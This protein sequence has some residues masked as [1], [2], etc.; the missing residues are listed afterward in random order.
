MWRRRRIIDEFDEIEREID[1]LFEEFFYGKPMWSESECLEPLAY[2]NETDD[3]IVVTV[4]LPF[5]KK[6]DIKLDVTPNLLKIE[7]KMQK[8]VIYDRWGTVQRRC[9][10]KTFHKEVK[11]PSEVIP[12]LTKAKFKNGYLIVTLP[13]KVRRHKIEIE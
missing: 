10:F 3:L 4:D 1:K 8:H 11:L 2:L 5:V 6:E 12:E 13:K 9:K 7:A